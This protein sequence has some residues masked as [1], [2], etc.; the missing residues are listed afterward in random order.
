MLQE[1]ISHEKFLVKKFL[2]FLAN[3]F[4]RELL[5]YSY[6]GESLKFVEY[7]NNLTET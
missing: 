1:P 6:E 3:P 4:L 5:V 2:E 7:F